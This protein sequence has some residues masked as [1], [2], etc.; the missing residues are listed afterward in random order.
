MPQPTS[1][2]G[3]MG[4]AGRSSIFHS[5]KKQQKVVEQESSGIYIEESPDDIPGGQDISQ[6]EQ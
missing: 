1:S 6:H 3:F 4:H 2:F 5:T